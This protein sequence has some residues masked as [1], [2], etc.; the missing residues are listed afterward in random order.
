MTAEGNSLPERVAP[1]KCR[2]TCPS[3]PVPACMT[4][5]TL[6]PRRSKTAQTRAAA[7][8]RRGCVALFASWLPARRAAR[9]DPNIALRAE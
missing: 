2:A 5:D 3:Q 1:R 4:R 7:V 8:E 6:V 9:V